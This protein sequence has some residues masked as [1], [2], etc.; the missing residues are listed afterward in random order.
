ME[1][2]TIQQLQDNICPEIHEL[3]TAVLENTIKRAHL[4]KVKNGLHLHGL[5]LHHILFHNLI[6]L[7]A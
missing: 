3:L 7:N 1:D 6:F 2:Q 4:Y 5:H